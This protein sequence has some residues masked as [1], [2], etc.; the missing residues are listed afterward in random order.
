LSLLVEKMRSR[1]FIVLMENT[2]IEK[3]PWRGPFVSGERGCG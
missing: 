3:A 1:H 2:A